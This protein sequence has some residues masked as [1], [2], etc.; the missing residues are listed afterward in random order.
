MTSGIAKAWPGVFL[1]WTHFRLSRWM[2]KHLRMR[3]ATSSVYLDLE[4]GVLNMIE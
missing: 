1:F 4:K 2:A 3:S